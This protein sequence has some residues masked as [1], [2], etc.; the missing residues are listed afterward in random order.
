VLPDS[1]LADETRLL[2]ADRVELPRLYIAWLTTAMFTEGDAELDL[3]ADILANGKTSRLYRRLVFEERIATDVSATQNSRESAGFFQVAATAAPGYGL[4]E[5]ERAIVEEIA[6]LAN[7]GPTPAELERCRVQA[8]S[9][10]MFRL[11]TV[12]GFGG[13]S[14]QL[15]AYNTFLGDPDFFDRDLARYQRV[16]AASIAA[17]VRGFLSNSRRVGLSV[18][19][20]E[21]TNLALPGSSPAAVS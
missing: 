7:D 2:I 5:I 4:V 18:V 21:R 6:R 16:T 19:P 17:T 10:F 11:Q 20:L 14:D 9:Q 15:N 12:G 13:K 3:A 1:P 8:E